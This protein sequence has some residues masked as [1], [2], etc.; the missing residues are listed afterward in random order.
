MRCLLY[1]PKQRRWVDRWR[2]FGDFFADP[3]SNFVARRQH[4]Q[5]QHRLQLQQQQQQRQQQQQQGQGWQPQQQLH[6]LPKGIGIKRKRTSLDLLHAAFVKRLPKHD[7]ELRQLLQQAAAA[8]ERKILLLPPNKDQADQ[9]SPF[10][11]SSSSSDSSKDQDQQ[12]Q[13]RL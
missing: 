8:E 11:N 13:F 5:Q 12:P 2:F 10:S 3:Y 9:V 4:Q 6:Q 7:E 1:H